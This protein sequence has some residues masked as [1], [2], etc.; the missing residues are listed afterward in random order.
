MFMLD[1][2][3]GLGGASQ[4]MKDRGWEVVRVDIDERFNPD[5]IADIATFSWHGKRPDLIWA[6]PPCTEFTKASMPWYDF[7]SPDL[8]LVNHAKRI[9]RE[10]NPRYWVIENVVGAIKFLGEPTFSIPPF[11]FWGYFPAIPKVK[12]NHRKQKFLAKDLI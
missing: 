10:S 7:D 11:F 12:H 9:I 8:S 6:S 3:S 4:A 2:F 5:I 1:L